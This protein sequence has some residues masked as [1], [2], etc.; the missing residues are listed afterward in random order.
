MTGTLHTAELFYAPNRTPSVQRSVG[1]LLDNEGTILEFGEISALAAKAE[2]RFDHA[3]ITP[4]LVN[5]HI[6]LTDGGTGEPV[7][8]GEGLVP[9]VRSLLN[10]RSDRT[11]E[12]I[13]GGARATL[14]EIRDAGTVAIGEVANDLRTLPAI[15]ESGLSTRFIYELIG[16]DPAG[17]E[18]AI[19]RF[20]V[21]AERG[22]GRVH[23]SPGAHAPYSVSPSLMKLIGS[24]AEARNLPLFIHL[25][26]DPAERELYEEGSG[27]WIDFLDG[28]GLPVDGFTSI[29]EAPIPFF[30]R[31]GL[32][33]PGFVGVHLADATAKELA[34]LASRGAAAILSPTSNLHIGDRLPPYREILASGLRFGL[35]TDGR[36]S[37]RSM[38]VL[39]EARLL[40]NS[41]PEAPLDRLLRA[42]TVDGAAILGMPEVVEIEVG[43]NVG[44][45]A[46]NTPPGSADESEIMRAMLSEE[47]QIDRIA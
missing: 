10:H 33:R 5:G 8:G 23:F 46:H 47:N 18:S 39:D 26:E 45:L 25:A 7:P 17:A 21:A 2:Q 14:R 36:G 20:R 37:S 3:L 29:G 9:W 16:A 31:L 6:H 28:L 11:D 12:E 44:L 34:L 38:N 43:R 24:E 27:E 4:G 1:V 42:L 40:S 35:G 22:E 15:V 32:L 30:D 41:F 19:E 13:E